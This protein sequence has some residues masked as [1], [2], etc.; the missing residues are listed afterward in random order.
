MDL[1]YGLAFNLLLKLFLDRPAVHQPGPPPA[2]II[3]TLK[4]EVPQSLRIPQWV[5][6]TPEH[7]FVGISGFCQTIEEARQQ[8][9]HSAIAQ[10][11]QTMGAEYSLDHE[12]RLEGN[13]RYARHELKERLVYAAQWFVRAVNEN[14]KETDI[15]DVKG[16]YLCFLLVRFPPDRIDRLRRLTIGPC[17]G[18][19][20]VQLTDEHALV[21]VWENNG[22]EISLADFEMELTKRNQHAYII[23]MFLW[24]IPDEDIRK[25]RGVLNEKIVIKNGKAS[26]SIPCPPPEQNIKSLLYG[27]ERQLRIVLYGYDEIGR[28][29]SIPV[30]KF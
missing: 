14:V 20:I 26:F 29:L 27:S 4:V 10:I 17:A 11:V 23:T 8:A 6:H 22:V 24:K 15:Q 12:S 30:N 7:G 2:P 9:I 3:Q 5:T 21:E 16:K 18:A 28:P 1:L 25:I 19:R 13:A